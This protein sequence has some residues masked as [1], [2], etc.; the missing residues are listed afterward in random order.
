MPNIGKIAQ[1]IGPIV[2]VSFAD[3]AYLPKINDALEIERENG[4]KVIFEVQQ[5]LG[6]DR[7]RAIAMDSTDGLLRG[8]KVLDTEA[9]IKMP[10]GDDIKGR[11]FNVVGDAIDGIPNLDKTNGRSIHAT[12]PRFED[13]STET[14]VL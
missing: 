12:P 9:A 6:E 14:E 3:D 10:V 1:I 11:V 5:H 13:L 2:D 4:Q 7:V 8:M